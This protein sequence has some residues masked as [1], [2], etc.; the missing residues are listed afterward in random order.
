VV[1]AS[2]PSVEIQPAPN[3]ETA[4]G[5]AFTTEELRYPVSS[6]MFG[7]S[8]VRKA[9]PAETPSAAVDVY[10]VSG[11]PPTSLAVARE[12]GQFVGSSIVAFR[13]ARAAA[14]I[15][16]ADAL[17]MAKPGEHFTLVVVP[18]GLVGRNPPFALAAAPA[19]IPAFANPGDRRAELTE[20]MRPLWQGKHTREETVIFFAENKDSV[21]HTRLLHRP[22]RIERLF[23]YATGKDYVEGKDWSLEADGTLRALPGT[24]LPIGTSDGLYPSTLEEGAKSRPTTDGRTLVVTETWSYPLTVLA[25][26]TH[27]DD[28]N[29]PVPAPT[30]ALPRTRQKLAAREPVK[31]AFIGDSIASPGRG[32]ATVMKPPYGP[33]WPELFVSTLR[34]RFGGPIVPKNRALGSTVST[35]GAANVDCVIAPERPDLVVIAFGMNDQRKTPP[36]K[37]RAN[38]ERMIRQTRATNPDA[39]FILV[40]SMVSNPIVADEQPLV[41]FREEMRKLAGN[42]IA[43]ADV[44]AVTRHLLKTKPS[45]DISVNNFN[46]PNDYLLRWYA[47]VAAELLGASGNAPTN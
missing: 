41:E 22:R 47:Q 29:G 18:V 26:Y 4:F 38:L 12:R 14:R 31:I 30:S 27:D 9:P 25:N 11:E 33:T 44:T 35:W 36:A 8:F 39:E 23:S 20:L 6:V 21:P 15:N 28:W 19:P 13:S 34:E 32:S 40:S 16:L 24:T 42:G 1:I 17:N 2:F 5:L 45:I 37:F 10:L 7:P 43:I 3:A 46:H